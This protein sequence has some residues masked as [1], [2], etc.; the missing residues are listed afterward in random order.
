MVK[1]MGVVEDTIKDDLHNYGITLNGLTHTIKNMKE[2]DLPWLII[3][4]INVLEDFNTRIVN[5]EKNKKDK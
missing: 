4:L 2:S 3:S 5:L 1:Y